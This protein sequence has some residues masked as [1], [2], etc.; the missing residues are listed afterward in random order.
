M[1]YA[2]AALAIAFGLAGASDLLVFITSAVGI[3]PAA[4]LMSDATEHL[5]ARSGTAVAGLVNV[6]L[7]N[8]PELIISL[9]A[10]AAGLQEV[11]KAA[12]VGSVI[13]NALLVLGG[14]MVVGGRKRQRQRFSATA[15]QTQA[16]LLVVAAIALALPAADQVIHGGPL[17]AAG[18]TRVAFPVPIQ[19]L[20]V[21]IAVVLIV[22]Y[23]TGLVFSLRTHRN[24]FADAIPDPEETVGWSHRRS[25]VAI[26]TGAVLVAVLSHFLV[27]T[28]VDASHT[29]G[30]SQFF[31]G[32]FIVAIVGNAAEHYAA[33]TAA[34]RDDMNLSMTMTVGS[35]SQV[36]LVIAPLLVLISFGLG[37]APM[38]LVFNGWEIGGLAAAA[39]IAAILTSDGESTWLEGIELLAVYVLVGIFF[40]FA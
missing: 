13:G 18:A 23:M 33:F 9:F 3:V 22:T 31:V 4:K 14:A 27:H 24:L 11:V 6:S 8:A 20:S 26:V 10:L 36:G 19:H 12:L 30:L 25:V 28:V 15:A 16:G 38:A 17:A 39:L 5:A 35:A 29:L 1:L 2:S 7:G 32:A 34:A 37:P 21:A 40:Y